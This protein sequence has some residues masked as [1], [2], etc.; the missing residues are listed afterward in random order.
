MGYDNGQVISCENQPLSYK[1]D[2]WY[3][4]FDY[5]RERKQKHVTNSDGKND[6]ATTLS[7]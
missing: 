7:K 5:K 2:K 3:D 6:Y 1:K 4:E